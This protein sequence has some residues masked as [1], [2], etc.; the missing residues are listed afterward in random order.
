MSETGE[1]IWTPNDYSNLITICAAAIG[2]TLLVIFKSRCV[3]INFCCGLWSCDRTLPD[4][5]ESDDSDAPV[6][7]REAII[8]PP[9]EV[10][11]NP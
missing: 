2:S 10:L 7:N 9:Q 4:T 8:P 6:M 5:D 1:D 3:K 11:N